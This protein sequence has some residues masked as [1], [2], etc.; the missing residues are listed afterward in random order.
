M[1][2]PLLLAHLNLDVADLPR[3]AA[4]YGEHLEL[5]VDVSDAAVRVEWPSFLLVLTPGTPRASDNF[6]FG[7]RVATSADVDAWT[8][9]L[10][11]RNVPIVAEA[12]RRGSVY[13]ARI[14]DPDAY[15]I[16]VFTFL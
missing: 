13:V 12:E 5:P 2:D 16:E 9:R 1:D 4:F 10:R 15:V 6:H 8:S 3:S 11:A 7:F 14:T